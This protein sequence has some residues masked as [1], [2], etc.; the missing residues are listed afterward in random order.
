MV[1]LS[2]IH[3]QDPRSLPGLINR[4]NTT[5][6]ASDRSRA[7]SPI[8]FKISGN[9]SLPGAIRRTNGLNQAVFDIHI[10]GFFIG[11]S[12]FSNNLE[13]G[14]K[15]KVGLGI[16]LTPDEKSVFYRHKAEFF[17]WILLEVKK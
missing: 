1:D 6:S 17:I 5:A 7:D 4:P 12:G 14:Q 9:G 10:A 3:R 2:R 15:G 13:I 8:S 11:C 16:F